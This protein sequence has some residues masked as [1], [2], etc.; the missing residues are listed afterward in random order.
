MYCWHQIYAMGYLKFLIYWI[1]F[2]VIYFT[3]DFLWFTS[4]I[5]RNGVTVPFSAQRKH[6]FL[7]K[8]NKMYKSKKIAPRNKVALGLLYHILG[9]SSTRSLMAG[10]AANFWMDI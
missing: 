3:E 1:W 4:S 5:G 6:D 10:D 2:V 9:R 7:V 8:T